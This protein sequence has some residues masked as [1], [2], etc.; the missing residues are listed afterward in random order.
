M[1]DQVVKP[2]FLSVNQLTGL[3]NNS[4]QESSIL[5]DHQN[6]NNYFLT[7]DSLVDIPLEFS[8]QALHLINSQ[9]TIIDIQNNEKH[10]TN[11]LVS[12]E[13]YQQIMLKMEQ[14]RYLSEQYQQM[15]RENQE[16]IL[17]RKKIEDQNAEMLD[18]NFQIKR[19]IFE[20]QQKIMICQSA[21]PLRQ[22]K[23][24]IELKNQ[25]KKLQAKLA[26]KRDTQQSTIPTENSTV[27]S[28]KS[29]SY[30]CNTSRLVK[31]DQSSSQH[32]SKKPFRSRNN[33]FIKIVKN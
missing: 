20:M 14:N 1:Q 27:D 22:D 10:N 26:E 19:E 6:Y 12:K 9:N 33:S 18:Q 11:V 23:Q 24:I 13:L 8:F 5:D 15:I 25:Y 3:F 16:Q 21:I 28:N 32:Q 30:Y 31:L 17:K 29:N 4:Q 2:I 7:Q